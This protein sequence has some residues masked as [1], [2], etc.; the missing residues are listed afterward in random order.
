M[1]IVR[2]DGGLGNSMFQYALGRHLSLRNGSALKFDISSYKTNPVADCSFWLEK[3]NIDIKNNL[4]AP[5][6]IAALMRYRRKSGKKWFLYNA[7]FA[8]QKKYVEEDANL[9]TQEIMTLAG[10]LYLRGWWQNESYFMQIRDTLLNDFT[11]RAPLQD[12]NLNAAEQMT[13]SNSV[14]IHVRRCDYVTNPRTRAFHGE[15][16]QAYYNHAVRLLSEHASNLKLFVFSDDIQWVHHHM[17]FPETT[18]YVDWNGGGIGHEDLRLMALCK[19]HIIAN[20]SFSWWGAWLGTYQNKTVIAP[21]RW[22]TKQHDRAGR[23]PPQWV[24]IPFQ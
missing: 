17:A 8:D 13:S 24:T 12:K 14:S 11:P 6:E 23:I 3:F 10:D 21:A 20:S 16:T 5:E 22:I 15:L 19:H 18:T 7:F 9:S 4:A 2:L 1:I